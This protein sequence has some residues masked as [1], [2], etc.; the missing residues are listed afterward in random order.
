MGPS[1]GSPHVVGTPRWHLRGEGEGGG[2]RETG[3]SGAPEVTLKKR[4]FSGNPEEALLS[5][6]SEPLP[7][8]HVCTAPD[9]PWFR[10]VAL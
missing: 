6:C 3:N 10:H 8:A 1:L 4:V 9:L 5:P 7:C 2:R